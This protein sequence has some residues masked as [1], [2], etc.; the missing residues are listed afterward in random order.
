[1]NAYLASQLIAQRQS[2]VAADLTT[3]AQVKEARA[4]RKARA[5][6]PVRPA[7][8]RRLPF[9]RPAPATA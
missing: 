9:G 7:R 4:A 3:R 5:T 8:I 6:S 1:M 2:A